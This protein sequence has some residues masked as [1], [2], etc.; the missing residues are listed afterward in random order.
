MAKEAKREGKKERMNGNSEITATCVFHLALARSF[1]RSLSL[2]HEVLTYV[3][4]D[5]FLGLFALSSQFSNAFS[6]SET[7]SML[8]V[9]QPSHTSLRKQIHLE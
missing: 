9:T 1:G 5:F 3:S 4:N 2:A 8:E 6:W 7:F